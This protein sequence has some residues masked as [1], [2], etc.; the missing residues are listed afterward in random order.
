FKDI[1]E[2]I[3]EYLPAGFP[4][5]TTSPEPEDRYRIFSISVPEHFNFGYDVVDAWQK[6]SRGLVV[7]AFVVLKTGF[8]P[9]DQLV[10]GL[11]EH[12]RQVPGPYKYLRF[13]ECID[14]LPRTCSGKMRRN[15]LRER[16]AKKV[17]PD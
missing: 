16:E 15:E 6:K 3:R 7:K 11:Q 2:T 8:S 10:A 14:S 5:T 1:R 9:S 17:K 4:D 13:I 12:V